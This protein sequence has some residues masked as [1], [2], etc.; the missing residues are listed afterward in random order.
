[1]EKQKLTIL[2]VDV[3]DESVT[4][5]LLNADETEVLELAIYRQKYDADTKTWAKDDETEDAFFQQIQDG[6][7]LLATTSETLEE[8]LE[9]LVDEEVELFVNE[10]KGRAYINEPKSLDLDKPTLD[11]VDEIEDGTIVDVID[12]DTKRLV[13]VETEDGKYRRPVNFSYG[14]LNKRAGKYLVSKVDLLNKQD[15]FKKLTG[16]DWEKGDQIIGQPAKIAIESF[17]MG[18]N[19]IPYCSLK[20]LKSAKK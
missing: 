9:N 1:M 12:F 15:K 5:D 7:G 14:K 20:K 16:L 4:I 13:I 18:G 17:T 11:D 2:A 19:E 3:K 10:D 6:L 8:D